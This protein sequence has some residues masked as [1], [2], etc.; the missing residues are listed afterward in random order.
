[1]QEFEIFPTSGL[2][3][4]TFECPHCGQQ[5]SGTIGIPEPDYLAETGGDSAVTNSD[6]FMC[7]SC[8]ETFD[9][10]IVNTYN[11]GYGTLDVNDDTKIHIE[12]I[13]VRNDDD[14]D[15]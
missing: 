14:D 10:E 1:M 8:G 9:V 6:T 15:L 13:Q 3:R 5:V 4:I 7:D 2:V 11:G 12:A